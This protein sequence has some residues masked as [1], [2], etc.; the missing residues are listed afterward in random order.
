MY[1]FYVEFPVLFLLGYYYA[2]SFTN[3][4]VR[5]SKNACFTQSLNPQF[6]NQDFYDQ[7]KTGL[8]I[9]CRKS[10]TKIQRQKD[11]KSK[12]NLYRRLTVRKVAKL[13]KITNLKNQYIFFVIG[14]M[15]QK[16]QQT[17]ATLAEV[18][19][20]LYHKLPKSK[21]YGNHATEVVEF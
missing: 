20:P 11:Q 18:T 13:R 8:V 9:A 17:P 7:F 14:E 4:Y 16:R 1:Q 12:P 2:R 3:F 15:T 19:E 21:T 10:C 5:N 6:A